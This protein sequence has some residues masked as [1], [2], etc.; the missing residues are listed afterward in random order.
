MSVPS[1]KHNAHATRLR[2]AAPT[3]V[4]TSYIAVVSLLL[5]LPLR[6]T[7]HRTQ[8]YNHGDRLV[9]HA[10][11]TDDAAKYDLWFLDY[12]A[13]LGIDDIH[14]FVIVLSCQL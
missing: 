7:T 12:L 6:C 2:N 3:R 14:E 8:T 4:L 11:V 1:A 10:K 9:G 13:T 5:L